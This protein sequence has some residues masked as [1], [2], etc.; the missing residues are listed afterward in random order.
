MHLNSSSLLIPVEIEI[1]WYFVRNSLMWRLRGM[2]YL[3]A[4]ISF[5]IL[6]Q[7]VTMYKYRQLEI[8]R[9]AP[10]PTAAGVRGG[11]R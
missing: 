5:S 9:C 10:I 8:S 11:H 3:L 2:D 4:S 1:G 7:F 6:I